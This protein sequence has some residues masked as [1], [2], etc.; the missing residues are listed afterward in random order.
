MTSKESGETE[1][2]ELLE[3]YR[4]ASGGAASAPSDAVRAAILAESRRVAE[5]LARQAS[6]AKQESQSSFD[7]SRPAAN[8]SRWKI[9]AFGTLGAALLAALLITPRYWETLPAR[10]ESAAA[11]A[12]AKAE[13]IVPTAPS[14]ALQNVVVTGGRRR[15]AD[16]QAEVVRKPAPGSPGD[17]RLSNAPSRD[18]VAAYSGREAA[19]R[20]FK[21]AQIPA[22]LQSAAESGDLLQATALLDKGATI[23]ARDAD[24]R[25]P[26]MLA[27]GQGRLEIVRLLLRRGADPNAT[28]KSG[29]RPLQAAAGQNFDAIA[30]LLRG[31][32]AH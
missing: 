18:A 10:K 7:T 21:R 31:A 16:A 27:V 24:G 32:G 25:T 3:R 30:E 2:K 9:T 26:L 5:Q 12:A 13:A 11:P 22:T 19:D 15:Q 14:D 17:L 28:D 4:R 29:K 8:D 20:M 6:N 23:D 1:D